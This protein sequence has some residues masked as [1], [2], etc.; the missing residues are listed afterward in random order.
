[1]MSISAASTQNTQSGSGLVAGVFSASRARFSAR[2][3]SCASPAVACAQAFR[4]SS[5]A[6]TFGVAT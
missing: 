1:M 6:P 2:S 4:S 3:A 5:S